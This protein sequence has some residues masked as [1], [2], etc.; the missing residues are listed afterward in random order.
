MGALHTG[1]RASR[2][3]QR[4]HTAWP[5]P[6]ATRC[7]AT[8]RQTMHSSGFSASVARFACTSDTITLALSSSSCSSVSVTN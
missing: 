4:V 3:S 2:G 7:S 5:Q 8:S 6:K 1:H